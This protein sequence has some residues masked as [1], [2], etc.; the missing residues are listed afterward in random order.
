MK[1]KIIG[2]VITIAMILSCISIIVFA[3]PVVA[4]NDIPDPVATISE[5]YIP[6]ET[7]APTEPEVIVLETV[8]VE[9][10]EPTTYEEATSLLEKATTRQETAQSV[11][12]GL[13]ALGYAENHPA[14][15]MAK[16]D[17][18]TSQADLVYYQEQYA[19]FEE[20]HKWEVRAAEYPVA[21]QVWLYMRDTLGWNEY[22]CAGIM[23]NMMAECGG[24]TLNL[25]WDNYNSSKHYGLCQWSKAYFPEMQ[26]ASLETQ[27]EF[28][29]KSVPE[30][31][32]GWAGEVF[33]YSYAEFIALTDYEVAARKFNDIYE[34]PGSYSSQ[35]SRNA[36]VAYEYFT[37]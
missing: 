11:Y 27:L 13:V 21:T 35:R 37:S 4:S 22:V 23:G 12:D 8:V 3:A 18:E 19:I 5:D 32:D 16:S 34:R 7:T 17:I 24:Q 15:V 20:A 25:K 2:V 30:T 10:V 9:R 33:H 14:V 28:L 36:Q 26:G 31:F 6:S 29:G 1:Q